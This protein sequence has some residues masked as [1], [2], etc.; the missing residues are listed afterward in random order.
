MIGWE[1]H[2][3]HEI[4]PILFFLM[5]AVA[6]PPSSEAQRLGR[7]IA[8]H[9]TLASL[10]PVMEVKETEE[11]LSEDPT[12][13]DA[14]KTQL[15]ATAKQVFRVSYDRLMTATGKAY[16]EQLDI[17]DLRA[18]ARFYESPVAGRYAGALQAGVM[19]S[20]SA[21]INAGVAKGFNRGGKTAARAGITLGF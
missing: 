19:V 2:K 13:T 14:E 6:S 11:L 5:S 4:A 7:T 17:S 8:E 3:A 1:R 9:G 15:R 20:E 12:L 10:L 18:L 21:A 16:A